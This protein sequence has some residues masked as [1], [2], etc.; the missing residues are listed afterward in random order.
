MKEIEK[1]ENQ[2]VF[3]ADIVEALVNAVRRYI[4]HVPVM[5]V[6]VAEISRNDSA[7]Y[8]ET[9]AHRI[10]LIPLKYDKAITGKSE[11]KLKL[12]VKKEGNVYSGD[13]KGN[14][15]KV[16][17]DKIPITTLAKGQEMKIVA[18]VR[19]GTGSEHA[20][21][22]PGLMFY[23]HGTEVA[24]D[25]DLY[26]EIKKICPNNEIKEKGD[27]IIIS[28]NL[29]KEITDVCEGIAQKT[30]KKAEVRNTGEMI[31]SIESFGQI[32]PEKMFSE[33]VSALKKDLSEFSKFI[34]KA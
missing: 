11:A 18:N 29:K 17:Y 20:K 28:D 9:V 2:I 13:M 6:D 21:F 15:I 32:T 12:E 34:D 14:D 4:H 19:P 30:K 31:I 8:D 7:L 33:S 24:L 23:R 26:E 3:S 5:A 22:S 10:G 16:V 27:K 1:N 25:K